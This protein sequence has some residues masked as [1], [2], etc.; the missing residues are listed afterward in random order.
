MVDVEG[1]VCA[2]GWRFLCAGMMLQA[3]QRME[4]ENR[5]K[6]RPHYMTGEQGGNVKE[7]A[8]QRREAKQW[9]DGGVGVVTFEECCEALDVDCDRARRMIEGHC[10]SAVK[11]SKRARH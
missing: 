3:V 7:T 6:I 4:S 1:V 9:L 2:A 11:R 5:A 8:Y 10:R